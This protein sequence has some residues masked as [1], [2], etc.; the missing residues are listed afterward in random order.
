MGPSRRF[1]VLDS[2]EVVYR[3]SRGSRFKEIS[4]FETFK[5]VFWVFNVGQEGLTLV[6]KRGGRVINSTF[7]KNYF[8]CQ[9]FTFSGVS[10]SMV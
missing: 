8:H 6:L 4:C 9:N 1:Q 10:K 7:L 5:E 2:L 3:Q